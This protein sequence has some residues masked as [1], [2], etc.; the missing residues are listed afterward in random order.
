M[1]PW[2][3]YNEFVAEFYD[4]VVPY[5][6]RPDIGFYTQM[7]KE[8]G[9]PVLELGCGTG[10]VLIPMARAGLEIVGLDLSTAMLS[11]CVERVASEP[12]PVR[13]KVHLTQG[14]MRH[15]DFG[16]SFSL[17]TV[18]FRAFQHLLEIEDQ[19]SCLRCI[20]R[21]LI[22]GGTLILD[23]FN[24]SLERLTDPRALTEYEVEPEFVMPG[25]RRVVRRSRN[26]SRDLHKQILDAELVYEVT[27]PDGH[28]ERLVQRILLR[29][30]FRYEAE[31][32]LA[33]AGFAVAQVYAD[34]E[35]NPY[36]SRYPGDM[37][38]VARKV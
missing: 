21:H 3:D 11:V 6:N 36:G 38:F 16:R 13:A 15:F 33:R 37:I 18:P 23:L 8:A 12:E 30:L 22:P 27:H 5:R 31:H 26:L 20:Y 7:G 34:F 35:K 29:Y 25:G 17:V 10:R 14:D 9:E 24:P 32:L 4:H 19:L 28:Q 1:D 2:D